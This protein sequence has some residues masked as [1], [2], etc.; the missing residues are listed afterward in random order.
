MDSLPKLPEDET[1]HVSDQGLNFILNNFDAACPDR[2]FL[3]T[4]D[5]R[6]ELPIRIKKSGPGSEK[7][8]TF[9][10]MWQQAVTKFGDCSSLNFEESPNK[11]VTWTYKHFYNECQTFAKALISL[12]IQNYTTV[13]IIGF[14]SPEWAVA[15]SGSMFGNYVPVGIYTTNGPDACEYI[16]NHSECQ[17][18]LMEDC[19]H[20]KKY[21]SVKEKVNKVKYFVVWKDK[22]P[23]DLDPDFVGRVLTW[24]DLMNIGRKQYKPTRKEDELEE[25]M[26]MAKPGNCATFIYTSGTTGP[27]K[28]VMISHDNYTWVTD[29]VGRRFEF[30]DP[31]R[32]G[33]GRI[34]SMLP[35]SHVAAQLVDLVVTV[36]FGLSVF[37]TDPSALQGNLVKFLLI[38]KP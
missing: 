25:R 21:I 38:A 28:A 34:L 3:W 32:A 5:Y 33:K 2:N 10:Q 11:W 12:G 16:A 31:K 26:C 27:P 35:L 4:T 36:R 7:P 37:F 18:V 8:Y 13:N 17:I 24:N 1:L 22:V 30:D 9:N 19:S 15:F 20:L 23:A 29:A 14:N 6:T